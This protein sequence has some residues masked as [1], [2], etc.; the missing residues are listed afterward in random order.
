VTDRDDLRLRRIQ[1]GTQAWMDTFMEQSGE[2]DF[3]G[4]LTNYPN[5]GKSHSFMRAA[6]ERGEDA[7]LLQPNR[8]LRS[9]SAAA[10]LD[11]IG[12]ESV[13]DLPSFPRESPLLDEQSPH[14]S[15]VAAEWYDRGMPPAAIYDALGDDA[16]PAE[17]DEYRRKM[18]GDL[19]EN[20]LLVGDPVHS[21]L[22]RAVN[23]RHVAMDDVDPYSS[24]VTERHVFSDQSRREVEEYLRHHADEIKSLLGRTTLPSYD[25][26]S[27]CDP[28][29]AG[30]DLWRFASENPARGIIPETDHVTAEA[31]RILM[32][33][34]QTTPDGGRL[35]WREDSGPLSAAN[36]STAVK[37]TGARVGDF[38]IWAGVPEGLRD[39][40]SLLMMTATPV[41]PV[42]EQIF[43]DLQVS[44]ATYDS[45]TSGQREDYFD[46]ILGADVVQT[47]R[48]SRFVSGGSGTR[49]SKLAETVR[50]IREI[51]DDDPL[52]ISSKKALNGPLSDVVER[53][54]LET[55]NFA[56]AVGTNEFAEHDLALVW[57]AP[58]F[59]DD[60]VRR[61]A[62]FC[63]D[64]DAEPIRED[65][66]TGERVETRW[67]TDTSQRIYDNMTEGTVFQA[68]LRVGRSTSA[69][70]TVYVE[71][72]KIPDDVP[73]LKPGG[74]D[75]IDILPRQQARVARACDEV[76]GGFTAGQIS[77]L[78]PDVSRRTVYDAFDRL[79]ESGRLEEAGTGRHGADRFE[80][81]D[82]DEGERGHLGEDERERLNNIIMEKSH[83]VEVQEAT[84]SAI[85]S[86]LTVGSAGEPP[87]IP[88][89]EPDPGGLTLDLWAD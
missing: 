19:A 83:D 17:D 26:I 23:G 34:A 21:F 56:R 79:R 32:V 33:L 80:L 7:T 85:R 12:V 89:H 50:V 69:R 25:W 5:T 18:Q 59:G 86:V 41:V 13:E 65:P 55:V 58:H 20:D 8:D 68:M 57:G 66:E 84:P 2:V 73:R 64:M 11:G 82:G 30:A 60:Y 70:A 6:W 36:R 46:E 28:E 51:H 54:G 62:A 40:R 22:D 71:T 47:T 76:Q 74:T 10:A 27:A 9:E 78:L 24:F 4:V 37:Y 72:D 53:E 15:A 42:F 45:M 48:R 88:P 81:P 3:A 16:P 75:M 43:E 49:P 1:R 52:V 29:G 31:T 87:E 38:A 77:D 39:A 35:G 63:G 44:S 67:S 14:Y 61:V